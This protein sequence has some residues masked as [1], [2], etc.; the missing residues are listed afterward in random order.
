MKI[1]ITL[2]IVLGLFVLYNNHIEGIKKDEQARANERLALEKREAGRKYKDQIDSLNAII[3]K[4]EMIINQYKDTVNYLNT[5]KNA[6]QKGH[7]KA[8]KVIDSLSRKNQNLNAR[9]VFNKKKERNNEDS[10][11]IEKS[12]VYS[13]ITTE[14]M[15]FPV[16]S[17]KSIL[18]FLFI[19]TTI[20]KIITARNRRVKWRI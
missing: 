19:I 2:L 11:Q 12:Y 5:E 10:I 7:N 15:I 9:L 18:S 20:L 16:D 13:G 4:N 1:I 3:H 14:L 17:I 8:L 6:I